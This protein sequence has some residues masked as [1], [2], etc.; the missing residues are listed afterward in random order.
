[1]V[2]CLSFRFNKLS[3]FVFSSF[4]IYHPILSPFLSLLLFFPSILPSFPFFIG[5]P[6]FPYPPISVSFS[7]LPFWEIRAFHYLPSSPTTTQRRFF[8]PCLLCILRNLKHYTFI[9]IL[10][11]LFL[12]KAREEIARDE[13]IR[14]RS[15]SIEQQR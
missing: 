13:V 1:M 7:L 2:H 14:E 12:L 10:T 6:S 5:F 11:V 9:H 8:A 3:T 4:S 15:K